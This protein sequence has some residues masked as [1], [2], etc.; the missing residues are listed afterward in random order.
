MKDH[1]HKSLAPSILRDHS[2]FQMVHNFQNNSLG[3]DFLI[4]FQTSKANNRLKREVGKKEIKKTSKKG[5]NNR[6]EIEEEEQVHYQK[7]KI[8]LSK[9]F[10]KNKQA[11][12]KK[13]IEDRNKKLKRNLRR[14]QEY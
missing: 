4:K 1:S 13:K 7:K 9:H 12:E 8:L 5:D 11:K 2:S 6:K 14:H 3:G 10:S